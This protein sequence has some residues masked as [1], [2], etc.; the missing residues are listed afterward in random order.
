MSKWIE[1][2][3]QNINLSHDKKVIEVLTG[4][5]AD[6]NIYIEL[7]V[8]YLRELIGYDKLLRIIEKL[9]P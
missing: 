6:G 8:Y 2:D 4:S 9:S 3:P 7:P 1:I 5:D